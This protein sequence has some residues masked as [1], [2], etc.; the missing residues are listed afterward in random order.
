MQYGYT[1]GLYDSSHA[2]NEYDKKAKDRKISIST[3]TNLS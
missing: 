1:K 3:R 2:V